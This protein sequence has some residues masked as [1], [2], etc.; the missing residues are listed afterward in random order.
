MGFGSV[1]VAAVA[2]WIVG[3][4]WYM[5]LAS[6]W[7]AASGV[8]V[9]DT[10]RPRN[11]GALP[12]LVSLVALVLVAGMVRHT[13]ATAGIDGWA[14]GLV[15]GLGLGAFVAAPWIAITYVYAARPRALWLIDCGYATIATGV[16]GLVL[17][18]F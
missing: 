13:F 6:Q 16:I 5:T 11:G 18:L 14:E 15:G 10:G 8:P 12:H 9:D 2:A 7:M 3:A 17:G 4:A 1:V